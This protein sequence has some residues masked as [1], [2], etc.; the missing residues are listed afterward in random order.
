[1]TS[2]K[3]QWTDL[4][5]K[6]KAKAGEIIKKRLKTGGGE[7]DDMTMDA[8]SEKLRGL[9][10]SWELIVV[11]LIGKTGIL[12]IQGGIDTS[13]EPKLEKKVNR[14]FMNHI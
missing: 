6:T 2:I 7:E 5:S 4:K 9:V 12:G 14:Y 8:I 10:A 1:M 13:A 3:S 11:Q